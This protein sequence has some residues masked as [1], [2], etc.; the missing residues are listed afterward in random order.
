M[1]QCLPHL[2]NNQMSLWYSSKSMSPLMQGYIQS[3]FIVARHIA[4][5]SSDQAASQHRQ[6]V[7]TIVSCNWGLAALAWTASQR[8][9]NKKSTIEKYMNPGKPNF[10]STTQKCQESFEASHLAMKS[11]RCPLVAATLRPIPLC[12]P[13]RNC[14]QLLDFFSHPF[15]Q[16]LYYRLQKHKQEQPYMGFDLCHELRG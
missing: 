8:K 1:V 15:F 5:S 7:M 13:R 2:H 9:K 11:W 10:A 6:S 16:V 3:L 4:V 14:L 12:A